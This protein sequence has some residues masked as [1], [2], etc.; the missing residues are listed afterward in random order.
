MTKY[1]DVT[2]FLNDFKYKMGFYGVLYL[3]KR[4]KNTQSLF[5][6]GITSSIRTEIL[7]ALAEVDY[8]EGP[9]DE[10]MYG[11]SDMW[12]FGKEVNDK[13]V[14]IKITMG[15]INQNVLCISFHISEFAMKYPLKN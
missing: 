6:L 4:L 3:D 14:Y 7:N 5:D 15:T 12:I 2:N 10:K 11:G 8:C 9:L 1:N 13:E